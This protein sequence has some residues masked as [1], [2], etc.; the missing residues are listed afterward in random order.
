MDKIKV[1]IADDSD[2]MRNEIKKILENDY[3]IEVVA[4]VKNGKDAIEL[5]RKLKPDVIALDI[6]M[7]VMDGLTALQHIMSELNIPVV[8]IS[9]FTQESVHITYTALEL[10]AVDFVGKP[11]E[12]ISLDV[13]KL[14]SEIILKIK[15]SKNGNRIF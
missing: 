2:L 12:V 8:M 10:G 3:E 11:S 15:E 5:A 7:P 1:L 6:N 4:A 9:S 13:D 14:S